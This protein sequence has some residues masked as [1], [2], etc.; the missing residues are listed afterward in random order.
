MAREIAIPLELEEELPE[1][2]AAG[3]SGTRRAGILWGCLG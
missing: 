3:S 1:R 2:P